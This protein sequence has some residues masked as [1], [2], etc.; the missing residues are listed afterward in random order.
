MLDIV[1]LAMFAVVPVMGWSIYVVKYRQ[2]Y[3]LH[4]TVQL[5]LGLILLT[6]VTAFEI[7]MRITGWT[8]RA[9]PSPYWQDGRW[10]DWVDYS[11]MVHLF[12]AVPTA[13]LWVLVI[14]Q[15]LRKFPAPPMPNAYSP[16]HILWA[17]LAALEML[18]TAITGWVFYWL[19]FGAG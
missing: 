12:F 10:N 9:R 6:A 19:A 1:F 17:R 13:V 8:E 7:D 2:R 5:T 18:M 11:L 4:K 15:A 16:R 3:Q 14:V